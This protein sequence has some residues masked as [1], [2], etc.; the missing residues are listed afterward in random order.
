MDLLDFVVE[1]REQIA[2]QAFQ[3]VSL[4]VQCVLL[5]TV[6]GVALGVLCHRRPWA[7]GLASGVSSVGLTLPALALIALV[8]GATRDGITSAVVAVTFYALLVVWRNAVVG[9]GGVDGQ[10]LEAAQG[11]GMG[12]VRRLVR[13]QLPLAWPVVLSGVR[14]A[15][16]MT[17]GIAAIAAFVTGPGLGGLIFTGLA[18]LGGAGALESALTGTLLVVALALVLDLLLVLL[19]RL[20]TPRGIRA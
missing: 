9:L 11:I 14:V 13:V 17:M 20:T 1:R 5:A 10:L 2:F 16:Q 12:R 15:T 19:G 4:V 6:L 8:Y 18:R 3:H 7:R